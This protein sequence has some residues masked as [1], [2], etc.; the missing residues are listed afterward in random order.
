M[1]EWAVDAFLVDDSTAL[2]D[3]RAVGEATVLMREVEAS[4][5]RDFEEILCDVCTLAPKGF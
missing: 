1:G 3:E 4:M 5:Y 2:C